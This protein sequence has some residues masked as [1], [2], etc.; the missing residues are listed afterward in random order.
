MKGHDFGR[1]ACCNFVWAL[2]PKALR[3]LGSIANRPPRFEEE[4]QD[5]TCKKEGRHLAQAEAQQSHV[6]VSEADSNYIVGD[7]GKLRDSTDASRMNFAGTSTLAKWI[8][9]RRA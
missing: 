9:G 8:P 6:A 3:Y 1:A 2:A 4:Q 5:H 7:M